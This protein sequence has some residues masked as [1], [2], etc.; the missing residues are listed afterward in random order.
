VNLQSSIDGFARLGRE[1]QIKF[2]A[3]L[4]HNLTIAARDTYEFQSS[5]VVSPERLRQI[6]EIQHRVFGH[7]IA[8][9]KDDVGRYPDDVLVSIVLDQQDDR[10]RKQ[11]FWAFDDALRKANAA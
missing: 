10:L 1:R 9:L 4:G 5:H 11:A 6:N 8:L 3:V 7:I 2:L